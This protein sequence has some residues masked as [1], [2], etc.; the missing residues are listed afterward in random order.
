MDVFT[1][2]VERIGPLAQKITIISATND[3]ALALSQ[4]IAGGIT[5]VG[6]AEKAQLEQ[7]GLRVIDASQGWGIINHDLFT[8]GTVVENGWMFR[9]ACIIPLSACVL[10]P[11]FGPTRTAI[12]D[13]IL[14]SRGAPR[15][16]AGLAGRVSVN[17]NRK[18][19]ACAGGT[20]CGSNSVQGGPRG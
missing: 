18:F 8:L 19:V 1:S 9:S 12:P 5:R 4:W 16:K 17:G 11:P 6:A 7:L 2:S 15:F 20:I 14:N 3:R 13:A 10:P